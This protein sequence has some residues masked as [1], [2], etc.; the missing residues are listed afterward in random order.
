MRA[1]RLRLLR[2]ESGFVIPIVMFLVLIGLLLGAAALDETLTSRNH[3]VREDR[4]ARALQA[5]QAGIQT[6]LY[7]A[8]QIDLTNQKLSSGLSLSSIIGQLLTCPVPTINAQ[9]QVSGLTFKAI[10]SV[11]SPCPSSASSG[12]G[13]ALNDKEA[14]G[15]HDYFETR[16]VPGTNAAGDYVQFSPKIVASGVDDNGSNTISRRI[17]AVL[18]PIQPFRTLEAVNDL[19][20]TVPSTVNLLGINVASATA[21]NGTAAAGHDLKLQ[22]AVSAVAAFTGTNISLSGGLTEPSTL[23]YCNTYTQ[24]NINLSLVL[25]STTHASPCNGLVTRP[26]ISISSSKADCPSS[27]STL[28]GSPYKVSNDEIYN[29]SASTTVSFAPGDYVFC[30]FYSAGPVSISPTWPA[31]NGGAVRIFIDSPQSS[32]CSGFATHDGIKAGSFYAG[33]GVTNLL[34]TTHPSQAQIYVVGDPSSAWSNS[35]TPDTSVTATATG[36]VSGQGMFVYAP[37]STVTVTSTPSCV[38]VLGL[39]V[40]CSGAGT[41]AGALVGYNTNVSATA[42]TEDLGLLNYPL[43]TTLG[44]YY[45]KQYIEC[46][47]QFPL[48]D[49]NPA[50][51][52]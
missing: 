13:S 51:G 4:S 27:C 31:G 25:G 38:V 42:I 33:K 44:A 3:A 29:P 15:N 1:P 35:S 34:A 45:V 19:T 10:A 40:T 7:R 17:E 8:N 20:F 39:S 2:S 43:S 36:L 23:D 22:S 26:A 5:A 32:R 21:F 48:D 9:G 14:V 41:L 49:S 47:P 50:S 11:G 46:P 18:G 6:E 30:S 52:C 37:Q 16:L 12:V 24:T 28:F